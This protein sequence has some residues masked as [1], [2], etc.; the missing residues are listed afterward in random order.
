MIRTASPRSDQGEHNEALYLTSSFTFTSA[1]QAALRFSEQKKGN[2]YGRFTNPNDQTFAKRL[3][4]L[5]GGQYGIATAS[6]MAAILTA[7]LAHLKAGDHVLCADC[8]FGTTIGFF[9][10]LM[11][12]F[13]VAV[14]FVKL[15][16]N[17]AWERSVKPNTRLFFCETPANPTTEIADLQ[18]LSQ[19]AHKH[20]ALLVVDNCF[21]TCCVQQ[22]LK[23][24]ADIV[25]HSATKFIDGQG[26]TLGG[27]LVCNDEAL[28]KLHYG[29]IRST[30]IGMSAFNAWTLSKS[31][32]T[33]ALRIEKHCHNAQVLAERL[34]AH[35][36]IVKVN[37]PGLASHPQRAIIE[38]QQSAGGGVLSFEVK[39]GRE[40]AWKLIDQCQLLSIT[41]N[42]G[43]AKSTITHP[44]TTTHW[45]MGEDQRKATGISENL[46]RISVGLEHV[47]DI[48]NDISKG[49]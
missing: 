40:S 18:A 38:R 15:S 16:D 43:D 42:L 46:I 37:Y 49:L 2:I 30:G 1:E 19:I 10:D 23:H 13:D 9:R 26:R 14:T 44:A 47:D 29:V 39:G 8:V 25:M 33:L 34:D 28:H 24:G 36:E 27:A 17:D 4:C 32:E 3:A 31:L 41:A 11:A 6:G 7:T 35:P 21:C 22:P 12:K 5:E 20:N 48:Y 45:R